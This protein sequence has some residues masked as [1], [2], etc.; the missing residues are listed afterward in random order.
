MLTDL[1]TTVGF[2]I[3]VGVPALILFLF[4]KHIRWAPPTEPMHGHQQSRAFNIDGS[5]MMGNVV[6]GRPYGMAGGSDTHGRPFGV[7]GQPYE[8]TRNR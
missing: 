3:I 1:E 5:P 8:I 6:N 4:R 7:Y 2:A